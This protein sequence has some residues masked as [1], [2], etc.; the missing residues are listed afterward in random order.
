MELKVSSAKSRGLTPSDCASDPEEKE[1]SD[2][3]DDD[4]NHKHRRQDARSQ[5]LERDTA[6]SVYAR[7]YKKR[8]PKLFENGH[9]FRENESQ[10]SQS[11]RNYSNAPLEKDFPMKFEKRRPGLVSMPRGP[12]DLNQRIRLNQI[13]PCDAGLG[14]G[15]GRGRDPGS[16]NQHDSRFSSVDIASQMLQQGPITPS[17]FA[18]RGLPNAFGLLPGL[19]NGGLDTFHSI[20]LQGTVRAPLN[21]SLNIG[22]PR[23]RCRDFEERGF[24][25][26][27]DMCP[28]EHGVNHIVIKD[29]QSLSQFNLPVSLSSA[30]L[31][32]AAAGPGTLSSI[33]NPSSTFMNSKGHGK[34]TKLGMADDVLGLNGGFSGSFSAGGADSYDPD[35]P[36]WNSNYP[37]TS[38]SLLVPHSPKNDENELLLNADASV[39]PHVRLHDIA[40]SECPERSAATV[41]GSEGTSSSVWGRIGSS[42]GGLD[43]KE[44]CNLTISSSNYIE[45]DSKK[46]QDVIAN[47]KGTSRHGKSFNPE[48]VGRKFM[49]SSPGTQIDSFRNI[50]R[51]SQKAVRTLFVNGIPQKTNK[52]E[53]LL[54]HF[55]KFGRVIDTYI[56]SNSERAFVQFSKREEAEAALK[57]PDAV[58]G[59]RFIKLWWANRDNIPEDGMS[60]G[61]DVLSLAVTAAP[62]PPN[63]F[64]ANKGKDGFQSVPKGSTVHA[65]ET[66]L[67]ASDQPKPLVTN[68][69]KVTPPLQKKLESLEHLKEELR[70]KQELLDQKRNDFRRQLDRLAKQAT[71]VKFDVVTEQATKRQKVGI[72]DDVAKATAPRPSDPSA[73]ATSPLVEMADKIKNKME[74]VVSSCPEKS[75]A[76]LEQESTN[77]KHQILPVAAARTPFLLNR[78]KLDNRPT[79]F[80]VIPPLPSAF[81]NVA[82]L[83]E[84]FSSYG[85]LSMVELEDVEALDSSDSSGT[86]KNCSAC[87]TFKTRHSAEL[88][89]LNG[90]CWQG[91][92]M[93]FMWLTSCNSSRDPTGREKSPLAPK[94][95]ADYNSNPAEKLVST[96]SLEATASGNEET[97]NSGGR[98]GVPTMAS[99]EVSQPSPKAISSGEESPKGD[100]C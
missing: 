5:Y 98:D 16:W 77:S 14:R 46:D 44:N 74:N 1:V 88:A 68:S 73:A 43:I 38:T 87:I 35:Q 20:G 86:N 29:V 80:R 18:G 41:I 75:M 65:S 13:F 59:N 69:P 34:G 78:Y 10:A 97:D 66:S 31:A 89:Y 33:G 79:A 3:E 81:A 45:N 22:I 36:L 17:L 76:I 90:K 62:V 54:S 83:K 47:V 51:P 61:S 56:P 55:Q 39:H 50:R 96:V 95:H 21:S 32:G 52:K 94:F 91:H 99:Q 26:R 19:P 70:K 57:A 12:L 49:V 6:E 40:D 72:V 15:R 23:H 58:M 67:P 25:L 2:E 24:C 64:I 92:T 11:W 30:Q 100:D 37:K 4:R 63:P 60:G 85:H 8:D 71:G 84:H 48:D 53:A 27:G 9:P 42:K 7:P 82:V 93:Q 28:M